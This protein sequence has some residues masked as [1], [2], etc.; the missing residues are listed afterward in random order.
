MNRWARESQE[1]REDRLILKRLPA[2][3]CDCSG[4]A[5]RKNG[6]CKGSTR[7]NWDPREG[8]KLF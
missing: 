4:T 1:K 3:F 7:G 5:R 2:T 8:Q 6:L